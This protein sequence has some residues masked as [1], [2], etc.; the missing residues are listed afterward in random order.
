MGAA[1]ANK[2]CPGEHRS[3]AFAALVDK[4]AQMLHGFK[5]GWSK[6]FYVG[7]ATVEITSQRVFHCAW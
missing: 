5:H 3:K 1:R 4:V 6:R 7:D 2:S